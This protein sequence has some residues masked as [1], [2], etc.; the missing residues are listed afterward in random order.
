VRVKKS[1][2]LI[3]QDSHTAKKSFKFTFSVE[4]IPICKDDLVALPI[5]LAKQAG[6]IS[7]LSICYKIGTS[8]YLLDPTTLQ[9]AD[10]SS[11]IYWRAPFGALAEAKDLVEFIVMDCEIVGYVY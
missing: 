3:S 2:E 11:P 1:S 9:T 10:I 5:S 4:L 8:V 7:P 6:N